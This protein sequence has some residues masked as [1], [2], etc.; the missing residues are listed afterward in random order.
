VVEDL[1]DAVVREHGEL[2]DAVRKKRVWIAVGGRGEGCPSLGY[3][4]LGT[5]PEE[6][7]SVDVGTGQCVPGMRVIRDDDD[8]GCFVSPTST[9]FEPKLVPE[10]RERIRHHLRELQRRAVIVVSALKR[11]DESLKRS[12]EI[13]NSRFKKKKSERPKFVQHAEIF[14]QQTKRLLHKG[15][16]R[17]HA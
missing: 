2:A 15:W 1:R 6:D 4:D 16:H 9:S 12:A 10:R 8:S 5:F 14:F 17:L 7:C 11:L 13:L 3:H